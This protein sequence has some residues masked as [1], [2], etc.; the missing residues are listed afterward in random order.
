MSE[1][2]DKLREELAKI[3]QTIAAQKALRGVLPDEQYETV[4]ASLQAQ[5]AQTLARMEG[6]GV[7]AQ[8]HSVAVVEGVGVGGDVHGGIIRGDHNLYLGSV[9]T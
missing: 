1:K 7:I 6:S 5:R 9:E 3:E 2:P 4:V 8:D